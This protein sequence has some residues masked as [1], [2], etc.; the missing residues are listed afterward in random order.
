VA[1]GGLAAGSVEAEAKGKETDSSG[2]GE[3]GDEEYDEEFEEYASPPSPRTALRG[4]LKGMRG[5]ESHLSLFG[6]QEDI[7]GWTDGG[8]RDVVWRNTN[9]ELLFN[10][11]VGTMLTGTPTREM[12]TQSDGVRSPAIK[13]STVKRSSHHARSPSKAEDDQRRS[14]SEVSIT[15]SA[16]FTSSITS[17]SSTK[18]HHHLTPSSA[19]LLS[20]SLNMQPGRLTVLRRLMGPQPEK[21]SLSRIKSS[22]LDRLSNGG[23]AQA[24]E[25]ERKA[26]QLLLA[27]ERAETMIDEQNATKGDA[28]DKQAEGGANKGK[29]SEPAVAV[30]SELATEQQDDP[31]QLGGM[32]DIL[33]MLNDEEFKMLMQQAEEMCASARSSGDTPFSSISAAPSP[34]STEALPSSSASPSSS[35]TAFSAIPTA[36]LALSLDTSLSREA[37]PLL[38]P[39]VERLELPITNR[40]PTQL[41]RDEEKDEEKEKNEQKEKEKEKEIEKEQNEQKEKEKEQLDKEAFNDVGMH[42]T[43]HMPILIDEEEEQEDERGRTKQK[44]GQAT[45]TY[46]QIATRSSM[47]SLDRFAGSQ[48]TRRLSLRKRDSAGKDGLLQTTLN[49]ETKPKRRRDE[50]PSEE[51]KEA[52]VNREQEEKSDG[53]ER[54]RS[55]DRQDVCNVSADE[56]NVECSQVIKVETVTKITLV[57]DEDIDIIEESRKVIMEGLREVERETF[58]DDL[59]RSWWPSQQEYQAVQTQTQRLETRESKKGK[60][61]VG[62]EEEGSEMDIA[63]D[64]CLP[65]GFEVHRFLMEPVSCMLERLTAVCRDHGSL[66]GTLRRLLWNQSS[67][68]KCSTWRCSRCPNHQRYLALLSSSGFLASGCRS[69]CGCVTNSPGRWPLLLG[70]TD[71]ASTRKKRKLYERFLVLEVSVVEYATPGEYCVIFANEKVLERHQLLMTLEVQL[72]FGSF[73]W[74]HVR[75]CACLMKCAVWRSLRICAVRGS[76][77]R[78]TPVSTYMSSARYAHTPAFHDKILS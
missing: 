51:P 15:N 24:V 72:A 37:T 49:L 14:R 12:S 62:D 39:K 45:D 35:S 41:I 53:G 73:L 6:S 34:S 56:G 27:L 69:C 52:N 7:Y 30:K 26:Q 55:E 3:D 68:P 25:D 66:P 19:A 71:A 32:E 75:Y 74:R 67:L 5:R 21:A 28:P 23:Q 16:T 60:E 43:Q 59:D 38:V 42:G 36:P 31:R 63:L 77:P 48:T 20:H 54:P 65:P 47:L 70:Q 78:S 57:E 9:D 13:I 33:E 61:K 4:R 22:L 50:A 40:E 44:R 17:G 18:H 58:L 8:E 29:L 2:E 46:S 76:A 11:D 1:A 10:A 64:D